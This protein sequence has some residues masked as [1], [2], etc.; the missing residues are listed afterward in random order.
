MPSNLTAQPKPSSKDLTCSACHKANRL[1]RVAM[2][3]AVG[4]VSV[5]AGFL[6]NFDPSK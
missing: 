1:S 6:K 3:M 4:V 5:T 2:T